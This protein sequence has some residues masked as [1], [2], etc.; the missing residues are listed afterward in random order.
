MNRKKIH[1]VTEGI[2]DGEPIQSEKFNQIVNPDTEK[3]IFDDV[4][5]ITECKDFEKYR[6]KNEFL[7]T[8]LEMAISYFEDFGDIIGEITLVAIDEKTDIFQ[9]GVSMKILDDGT[10]QYGTIDYKADGKILKFAD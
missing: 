10:F 7:A 1:F 3:I 8:V 9:W 4:F 5:Q 2:V 6:D